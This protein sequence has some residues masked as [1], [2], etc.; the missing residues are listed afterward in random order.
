VT[1]LFNSYTLKCINL[2]TAWFLGDTCCTDKSVVIFLGSTRPCHDKNLPFDVSNQF[3]ICSNIIRAAHVVSHAV[4]RLPS[5]VCNIS[6]L[7]QRTWHSFLLFFTFMGPCIAN[8]FK[9]NQQD[10]TLHNGIYYYKCST[11]FRRFLHP[12]TGAQNCIHSIGYLSSVSC[13]L[14]LSWVSSN[15]RLFRVE[16]GISTWIEISALAWLRLTWEVLFRSRGSLRGIC[17]GESGTGTDFTV[18]FGFPSQL[19][20]PQISLFALIR[21]P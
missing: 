10:A 15:S 3:Q 9:R 4:T 19:S 6:L 1:K 11:C 2:I 16:I 5:S 18:S 12:S 14:P 8:V 13:F 20:L 21:L 17:S 7:L